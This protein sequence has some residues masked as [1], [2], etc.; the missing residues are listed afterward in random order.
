MLKVYGYSD[1]LVEVENS[2]YFKNK[3]SEIDCF[4]SGVRIH[5][6]D[7]TKIRIQYGK[8]EGA[9]WDIVV[10]KVG[11]AEQHLHK[12]YDESETPYS[13]VFKIDSEIRKVALCKLRKV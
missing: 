6:E 5:F 13:D 7:G 8:A 3:A 10:E 11:N 12:C 4:E 1:D 9:I 2:N